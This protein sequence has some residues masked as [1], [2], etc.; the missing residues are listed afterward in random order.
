MRELIT[1]HQEKM[2]KLG[3]DVEN[4]E[5]ERAAMI[6][7]KESYLNDTKTELQEKIHSEEVKANELE[8]NIRQLKRELDETEAQ[9]E[10]EIDVHIESTKSK[11]REMLVEQKQLTLKFLGENGIMQ[12]RISSIQHD[13]EQ[14]KEDTKASLLRQ[15]DIRMNISSLEDS[16]QVLESSK[17]MKDDLLSSKKV[18]IESL[19]SKQNELSKYE[20]VLDAKIEELKKAIP[21][22]DINIG[23]AVDRNGTKERT[24]N[25]YAIENKK[26]EESIEATKTK[27][28]QKQ[29][30]VAFQR[31]KFTHLERTLSWLISE[32][33]E[34]MNFIQRP[35]DLRAKLN[36]ICAQQT[37]GD[38]KSNNDDKGNAHPTSHEH[39]E[40]EI[41]LNNT[42]LQ[43][44]STQK[45]N[46]SRQRE[47]KNL[48]LQQN[49]ELLQQ[50]KDERN[51]IK[52]MKSTPCSID[53]R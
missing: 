1:L 19:E 28:A 37:R 18:I 44:Q 39:V 6:K 20:Y 25:D 11:H 35:D 12:K 41:E 13:I 4:M 51:L 30:E 45:K 5:S 43:L 21:P 14:L 29:R 32:V 42:L 40:E 49:R 24:L 9:I 7:T 31:E 8:A 17:E 53:S 22:I 46:I 47:E 52:K 26:I 34:C 2:H 50:I 10:E 36:T 27:I 48:L 33:K 16:I 23:A 15:D 3:T 38:S